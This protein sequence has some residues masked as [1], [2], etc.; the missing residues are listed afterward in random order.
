MRINLREIGWERGLDS[1][2]SGLGTVEAVMYAVMNLLVF[3]PQS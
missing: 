3:G 1:T 2:G